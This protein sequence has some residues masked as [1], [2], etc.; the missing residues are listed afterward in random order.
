MKYFRA[1]LE[2]YARLPYVKR[3]AVYFSGVIE[4]LKRAM[5]GHYFVR[6]SYES[7][8]KTVSGYPFKL[9]Y[10]EWYT[11]NYLVMLKEDGQFEHY[12]I[13]RIDPEP[14]HINHFEINKLD[15]DKLK[16]KEDEIITKLVTIRTQP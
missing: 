4:E 7:D 13:C 14:E 3:E 15:T 8:K 5:D 10:D 12:R 16:I 2:E 11:Y 6:F 9:E 1:V